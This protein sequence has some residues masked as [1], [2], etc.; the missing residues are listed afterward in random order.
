M[1]WRDDGAA[2]LLGPA[3]FSWSALGV[4]VV[5][6]ALS[7]LGFSV[8]L[9]RHFAHAAFDC[10]V[11]TGRVLAWL[12]V[13]TGI[14]GP[15]GMVRA[16][17][18]SHWAQQRHEAHDFFTHRRS[19]LT[20]TIWRAHGRIILARAPAFD[21][22]WLQADPVLRSLDRTWMLQQMVL[23]VPLYAAGGW[24]LVIWGV[25]VRVAATVTAYWT[26]AHLAHRPE[27][28]SARHTPGNDVGWAAVLTLGEA[29]HSNNHAWPGSARIGLYPGQSD[30]GWRFI[31]LLERLGLAWNVRT[32]ETMG[33]RPLERATS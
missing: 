14:D 23:A 32:P 6:G 19:W 12:G 1:E 21:L 16:H 9:H 8:G 4:A 11:R 10:G 13:L 30:G 15:I 28:Q 22:G 2:V 24:P 27:G 17:H 26:L 5:L 20:H 3:T 31:Q 29:W 7:M 33:A 18:L 25:P